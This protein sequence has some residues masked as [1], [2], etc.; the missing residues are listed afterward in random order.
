MPAI[1]SHHTGTTDVPWDANANVSRISDDAGEA[2]LRRE[3]AWV[4]AGADPELKGSY[5]FPHH[6]VGAD[7]SPGAANLAACR[8]IKARVSQA[9]IPS[10]DDDGV[11]AHADAH[12]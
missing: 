6:Q 9:D 10:S 2:T 5:K 8:N 11:N 4:E 1:P 7:G 12:L 3:F